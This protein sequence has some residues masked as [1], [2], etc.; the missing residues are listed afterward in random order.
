[1]F[2]ILPAVV[3]SRPS[4]RSTLSP[5]AVVQRHLR[6]Q[7]HIQTRWLSAR[8]EVLCVSCRQLSQTALS[9]A[10]EHSY[11][12]QAL[13]LSHHL[14]LLITTLSSIFFSFVPQVIKQLMKKEFTLEFSRDRKSMSVYCTP[15]KPGSQ[16]KMFIKARMIHTHTH[17]HTHTQTNS[18]SL[19]FVFSCVIVVPSRRALQ[20]A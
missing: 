17:T 6:R 3:T 5:C 9:A 18:S 15:V 11:L 14:H 8:A 13:P 2:D 12:A 4:A 19:P 1:M 20:R 10:K 16:S 7:P